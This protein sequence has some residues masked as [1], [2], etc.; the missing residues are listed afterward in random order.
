MKREFAE[1]RDDDRDDGAV[2]VVLVMGAGI[3]FI[4]GIAFALAF[5]V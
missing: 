2:L 4:N 5:L 3:G 1:R